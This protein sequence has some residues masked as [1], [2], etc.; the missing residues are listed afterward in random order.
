MNKFCFGNRIRIH[1]YFGLLLQQS[2]FCSVCVLQNSKKP[3]AK[4]TFHSPT[5]EVIHK[6]QEYITNPTLIHFYW[7][8]LKKCHPAVKRKQQLP[9]NKSTKT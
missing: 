4:G 5:Y 1:L 2:V 9:A 7:E 8:S 3:S 6:H